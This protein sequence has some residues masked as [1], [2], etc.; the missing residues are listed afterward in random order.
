[1]N[2]RSDLLRAATAGMLGEAPADEA[3][4]DAEELAA[5]A[6]GEL[7][8]EAAARVREHLLGCVQCNALLLDYDGLRRGELGADLDVSEVEMAAVW[9]RVERGMGE[10]KGA[11]TKRARPAPVVRSRPSGLVLA[12]AAC[13][14]AIVGLGVWV[15]VLRQTLLTP[16]L[17]VPIHD[18]RAGTPRSAAT[19]R[20][21]VLGAGQRSFVVVLT[22][23]WAPGQ[24]VYDLI[25]VGADGEEVWR[26]SGL[27]GAA[28]G[29][30]S[31]TL[32]HGLLPPGEYR[33]RL[34]R[35]TGG[36]EPAAEFVLG[37]A[38]DGG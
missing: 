5:Y 32:P 30:F 21:L 10:V 36:G 8:E 38:E 29:T 1:M 7:S 4:M 31:M 33:L 11:S 22:P 25:I 2:D 20:P 6:A 15:Q 16:R 26:G 24:E 12:L 18:L 35:E 3:H 9:R 14:V 19:A 23:A 17:N 13:L 27:R 37:I 28:D 34:Y